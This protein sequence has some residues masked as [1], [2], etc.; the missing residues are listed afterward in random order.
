M[1]K[2]YQNTIIPQATRDKLEEMYVK[3][4]AFDITIDEFVGNKIVEWMAGA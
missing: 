4:G 3:E 2:V 1:C